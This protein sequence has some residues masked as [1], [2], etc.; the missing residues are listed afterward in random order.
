MSEA[1][2]HAR[3]RDLFS[4]EINPETLRAVRSC[5]QTGTPLGNTRFR[6]QIER[7]LG[8]KVGYSARGRPKKQDAAKDRGE[9]QPGLDP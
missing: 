6:A 1:E 4:T 2:R 9:D 5:V 3:Y 7:A 8:V